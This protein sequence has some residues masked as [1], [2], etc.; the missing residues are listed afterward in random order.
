MG[1]KKNCSWEPT[2]YQRRAPARRGIVT[3][4]PGKPGGGRGME[5]AEE[6]MGVRVWVMGE[7]G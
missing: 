3:D 1:F 5:M 6:G 4:R 7:G 2:Q